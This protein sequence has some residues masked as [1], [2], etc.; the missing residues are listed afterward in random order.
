MQENPDSQDRKGVEEDISEA[1]GRPEA[2]TGKEPWKENERESR[3][4]TEE[5]AEEGTEEKRTEEKNE[6]ERRTA[7]TMKKR[8]TKSKSN[9]MLF[10]VCGG[11]GEYLGIDPTLVRL[12]FV[13]LTLIDGVGLVI[14]IIL[15]VIMP[16]EDSVEMTPKETVTSNLNGLHEELK[17][18]G[19][20]IREKSDRNRL[21]GSILLIVG[22]YLLLDRTGIFWRFRWLDELFLPVILILGGAWL[23]L[24]NRDN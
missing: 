18:A 5:E 14:Y 8:L 13:A 2:E 22:A 9:R 3:K 15:A 16:T 17:Q 1:P 21:L 4:G 11:L 6:G 23:L 24:K 7:Y 20:G 10:G 12:A 19:G